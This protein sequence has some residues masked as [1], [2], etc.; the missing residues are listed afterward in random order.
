LCFPLVK[1]KKDG[2]LKR[3]DFLAFVSKRKKVKEIQQIG[4]CFGRKNFFLQVTLTFSDFTKP[5]HN[6]FLTLEKRLVKR[7]VRRQILTLTSKYRRNCVT[8]SLPLRKK[9]G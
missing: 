9:Y 1:I 5:L 2:T 7:E 8:T 6:K 3:I 4:I